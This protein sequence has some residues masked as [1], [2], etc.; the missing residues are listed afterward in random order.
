MLTSIRARAVHALAGLA[1]LTCVP[2]LPAATI[3]GS[4]TYSSETI[5]AFGNWSVQFSSS[6]PNTVLQQ[7]T[8]DLS[9]TT[10]FFDTVLGAPGYLLAQSFQPTGGSDISTGLSGVTPGG[11]AILDGGQLLALTF[12]NFTSANGPFTF[13]LD[14]DGPANYAGCGGGIL[15]AICRGGRNIDASLVSAEEIAGALVTLHFW[16]P[17]MGANVVQTNLGV[18]GSFEA[19]G[20]F[21]VPE[22][23]TYALAAAGL[24]LLALL[25]RRR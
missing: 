8:I 4:V 20:S 12:T 25:R 15:G 2:T 18:E 19:A 11:G 13:L 7:V 22:P 9:P 10:L 17:G 24:G 23:G 5:G 1:L 16:T 21:A 14:V 3:G 6:N